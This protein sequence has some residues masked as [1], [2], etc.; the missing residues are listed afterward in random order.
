M[1]TQKF[2]HGGTDTKSAGNNQAFFAS[3]ERTMKAL[4]NE[5]YVCLTLHYG[6][7]DN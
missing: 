4:L 1:A 7:L 5:T 2:H 3:E 6:V